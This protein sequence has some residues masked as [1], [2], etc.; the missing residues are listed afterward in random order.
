MTEKTLTEEI[1][2]IVNSVA[3]N[4]PAPTQGKITKIY[5]DNNHVDI[6]TQNGTLTYIPTISHRKHWNN[7]IPGWRL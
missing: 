6:E 1:I 3:N 2:T 7:N 5:S 4:N